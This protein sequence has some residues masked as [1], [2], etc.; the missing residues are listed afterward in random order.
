[1]VQTDET[2]RNLHE[3]RSFFSLVEQTEQTDQEEL[4]A[5]NKFMKKQKPEYEKDDEIL[6]EEGI[7][8]GTK[9]ILGI[10]FRPVTAL[11]VSWMQ[12]NE[13]FSDKKDLIWKSAAFAFLHSAPFPVI[14]S[15]VNDKDLFVDA[16]DMWI[17]KN[18]A[19]HVELDAVG[20]VM[21]DGFKAY[22]ASASHPVANNQKGSASGN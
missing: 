13:I 15:V 1:M 11:S 21:N 4:R 19:H 8:D 17:E 20:V 9:T 6:R 22:A 16:V 2:H 5:E 3:Q 14:R 10:D 12:R 7:T 18:I